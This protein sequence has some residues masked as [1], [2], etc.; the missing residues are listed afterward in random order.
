MQRLP[1]VVSDRVVRDR[2]PFDAHTKS[3][4]AV[5]QTPRG[6]ARDRQSHH[7]VFRGRAQE[8]GPV[9][10][11]GRRFRTGDECSAELCSVSLSDLFRRR[12][13]K[14]QIA[15]REDVLARYK[16]LRQVSRNLNSKLVECLSKDVLY[17]GGRKLGILKGNTLEFD[18][19]DETSVLMDY[20]IYD[21]RRNGCNA[22][23]QY[24]ISFPSDSESDELNCLRSMQR[25]IYSLFVVESVERGLGATVR[26][27]RTNEINLVVDTGFGSSARPGLIFASR[28]LFHDDFSM[29][30]GAALP[31]GFLPTEKR[32]NVTKQLLA[33]VATNDDGYFDPASLIR[34]CLS[35][36]CSSRIEYQEPGQRRGQEQ[37]QTNRRPR[38]VGRNETC[39][40]GSGRKYK[41]CCLNRF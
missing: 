8:R 37:L 28:L 26:D 3:G 41:H 15:N 5:G 13:K 35:N 39:P 10:R 22:I 1:R 25:A 38:K 30:G 23:E 16:H 21:V 19:E 17:E 9:A 27:M 31:I 36:G 34:S 4:K 18:S 12:T 24:L 14:S 20:C 7:G 33:A 32:D 40:C 29:T 11:V 6:A 2:F